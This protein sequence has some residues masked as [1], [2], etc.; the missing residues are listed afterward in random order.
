[1]SRL[2]LPHTH[3]P[4]LSLLHAAGGL[5]INL[6]T[7]DTVVIFDSDWNPQNDLQAMS[8]AHRIGQTE[9]VNIYRLVTSGSVE[10]DILERAK[11]K[12]VLDHLVIQRMDTSGRMVLDGG[13]AGGNAPGGGA[14]VGKLFGKDEL[15]AILRFGAEELFKQAGDGDGDGDATAERDRR[16]YEEDI[17][18]ILERAEVVDAAEYAAGGGGGS[19][20]D[21]GGG[22]GGDSGA[23]GQLLSSFNVATFK[24]DEDDAAF[25]NRLI[26]VDVRPE[27]CARARVK[28]GMHA[29]VRGGRRLPWRRPCMHVCVRSGAHIEAK[30]GLAGLALQACHAER[31]RPSRHCSS[32]GRRKM[33]ST[34][35]SIQR[36]EGGGL[37]P[38]S[39]LIGKKEDGFD[40]AQHSFPRLSLHL[41]VRLLASPTSAVLYKSL[42]LDFLRTYK[43]VSYTHTHTHIR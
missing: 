42:L 7:A 39:A 13:K 41:S 30:R 19:G 29:G 15:T 26:P 23:G 21:G 38:C 28:R 25:W 35:L 37:R 11:K 6:A 27:V 1:M 32:E 36:E 31:R 9:T 40:P 8:R 14:G 2:H 34:L 3:N 5:G 17:D 33:P 24:S 16:V 43:Y 10:E 18:A 4:P 22:E 20:T 12:M